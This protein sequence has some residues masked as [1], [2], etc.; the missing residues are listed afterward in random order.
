MKDKEILFLEVINSVKVSGETPFW[1]GGKSYEL[2]SAFSLKYSDF[3]HKKK[4]S[5]TKYASGILMD[6]RITFDKKKSSY[7]NDTIYA[8]GI[9]IWY[10]NYIW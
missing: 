5:Y 10:A 2:S 1:E 6:I 3:L 9:L 8:S 4:W 7:I